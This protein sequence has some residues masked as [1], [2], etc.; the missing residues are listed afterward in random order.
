M[1]INTVSQ[2]NKFAAQ[3]G[4]KGHGE[5]LVKLIEKQ[6]IVSVPMARLIAG[7]HSGTKTAPLI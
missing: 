2:L 7:Q 3:V 1:M 6:E 5:L 4:V